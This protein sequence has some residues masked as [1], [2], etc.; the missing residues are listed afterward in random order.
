M[1]V[2][3]AALAAG[4]ALSGAARAAGTAAA[5]PQSLTPTGTTYLS[6]LLEA[7]VA[8]GDTPGVVALVVNRDHVLYEGAAGHLGGP[9]TA[10]MPTNA[11]FAIASMTKP[12]TSVAIVQ[13]IERGKMKLDDPVSKYLPGFAHQQVITALNPADGSVQTA[14]AKHAMTIR[15]L[16]THTSGIGYSFSNPVVARLLQGAQKNEWDL[17]LL[18]EPGTRWTYSA[19]TRV[20]GLIVEKVSGQSL[21]DY[22]QTNVLR[23]L[24]MVDTSFA[25]PPEKQARLPAQFHR[26]AS[27]TGFDPQPRLFP[28]ASKPTP[29][30]LG[31]GGL[32][33]TAEDYGRFMQMFLNGGR[34]GKA[35]VLSEKSVHLMSE[36][37]IG[38][39][40]VEE[41]PAANPQLTK[42][43][44]LG[45]GHDKWGLGF[46]IASD[47]P[48][49][50]KYRSA[51]S[52]SWAGVFNTEFWIDPKA[53]VGGVVLMQ[54]LPFYDDGAIRALREFESGVYLL[55]R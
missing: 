11:I 3:T 23:P 4:L 42:P 7:A 31:D 33:S 30:Y 36:N 46:Q 27:S 44:P 39:L 48:D 1:K 13:L 24:G 25:V 9:S 8:R 28:V 49:S 6:H 22:L 2:F 21:E 41:Q 19:S 37:Q 34:L 18:Q 12:V 55:V 45:A 54:T 38:P 14:P 52:L 16:L 51:G 43:F 26:A 40:F 15:H 35:R 47:G 20:L 5:S 29:P 10:A 32:Y 50:A 17:P 53:H